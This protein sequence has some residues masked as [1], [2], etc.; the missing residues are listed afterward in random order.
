MTE[1]QQALLQSAQTLIAAHGLTAMS[2]AKIAA[3]A[4]VSEALIFRHFKS[5]NGLALAVLS[6]GERARAGLIYGFLN[7]ADPSE[8]L[9]SFTS[10]QLD[11]FKNS[12]DLLAWIA[13]IRITQEDLVRREMDSF[14]MERLRWAISSVGHGSEEAVA[15]TAVEVLERTLLLAFHGDEESSVLCLRGLRELLI[16]E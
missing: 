6:A 2:T 11:K 12:P 4:G 5:K 13:M 15:R 8:V 3:H 9:R 10:I 7:D 16:N 14:V 1:K